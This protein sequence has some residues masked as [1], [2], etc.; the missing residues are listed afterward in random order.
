MGYA[1][2]TILRLNSEKLM[3]LGW[4]PEIGLLEMAGRLMDSLGEGN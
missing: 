2:S 3:E 1:P 4:K